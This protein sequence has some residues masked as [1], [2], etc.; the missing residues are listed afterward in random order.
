MDTA[1]TDEG[2]LS[3][4]SPREELKGNEEEEE[5]KEDS[6]QN[7]GNVP[8]VKFQYQDT[9]VIQTIAS[10]KKANPG[11]VYDWE[12]QMWRLNLECTQYMTEYIEKVIK[13]QSAFTEDLFE[14]NLIV[15]EKEAY[16]VPK[17]IMVTFKLLGDKILCEDKK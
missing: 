17:F 14:K 7:Q 1:R 16:E 11:Q 9:E 6:L 3:F 15:E 13:P 4:I 12:A 8:N 10:V 5:K 2:Q